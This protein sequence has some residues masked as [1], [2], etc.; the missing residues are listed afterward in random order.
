MDDKLSFVM[1]GRV[2]LCVSL[3][4]MTYN[5]AGLGTNRFLADI[6]MDQTSL[7]RYVFVLYVRC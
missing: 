4:Q 3:R 5:F 6:E 1:R 2:T 7:E